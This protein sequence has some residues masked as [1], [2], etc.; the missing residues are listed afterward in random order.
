[1]S[2]I[3]APT[4]ITRYCHICTGTLQLKQAIAL[5][6]KVDGWL[7]SVSQLMAAAVSSSLAAVSFVPIAVRLVVVAGGC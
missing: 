1:M 6:V 3:L 2:Q 5:E 7:S 4:K